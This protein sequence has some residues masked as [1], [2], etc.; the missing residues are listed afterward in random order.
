V[1]ALKKTKKKFTIRKEVANFENL[2]EVMACRPLMIHISC[3]G[4]QFLD[5]SGDPSRNQF[6]LAF[7]DADKICMLDRLSEDRL[8]KLLGED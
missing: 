6:F 8:R 3:H 4:D 7:E 5:T 2:K 1:E